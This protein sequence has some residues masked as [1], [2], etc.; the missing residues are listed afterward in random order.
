MLLQIGLDRRGGILLKRFLFLIV[1]VLIVGWSTVALADTNMVAVDAGLQSTDKTV[2]ANKIK[3][4]ILGIAYFVGVI[5]VAAMVFNG[6]KIANPLTDE[7]GRDKAKTNI[8]WAL[9]AVV[10]VALALMIVGYVVSL[11]GGTS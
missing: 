3:D 5:A 1:L 8:G 10:I 11:V 7:Q 4:I 2:L 6:L 9:G